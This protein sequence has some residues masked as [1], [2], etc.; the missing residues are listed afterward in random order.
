MRI[1][2]FFDRRSAA[3]TDG[4]SARGLFK[5]FAALAT[6]C[7]AFVFPMAAQAQQCYTAP[8]QGG[9]RSQSPLIFNLPQ[10]TLANLNTN[11]V[12]GAR[13]A[14]VVLPLHR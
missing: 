1:S 5:W 4:Y 14:G 8:Y 7:A 2:R 3:A 10:I 12:V 6:L 13:M 9:P 11:V